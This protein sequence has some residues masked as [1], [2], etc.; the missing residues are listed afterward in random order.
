MIFYFDENVQYK[1]TEEVD[2]SKISINETIRHMFN[3]VPEN[4]KLALADDYI[5]LDPADFPGAE[6][7]AEAWKRFKL[8]LHMDNC[9][10]VKDKLVYLDMITKFG[11]KHANQVRNRTT[12]MLDA[13]IGM[14]EECNNF[15]TLKGR[16][17]NIKEILEARRNG[18]DMLE[19]IER[20]QDSPPEYVE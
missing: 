17:E 20:Q 1:M 10:T 13:F 5:E 7:N 18:E 8:K 11:F 14:L 4:I 2:V 3:N 16:I 19:V 12:G 15:E 9:K 6:E